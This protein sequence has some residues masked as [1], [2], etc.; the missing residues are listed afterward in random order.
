MPRAGTSAQPPR[1]FNLP[2]TS[3]GGVSA[4]GTAVPWRL[5]PRMS[6]RPGRLSS[7]VIAM[8][9]AAGQCQQ[10]RRSRLSEMEYFFKKYCLFQR[11]HSE[12]SDAGYPGR[13]SA[14]LALSKTCPWTGFCESY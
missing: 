14:E 3:S 2:P 11:Q 12:I 5:D 8:V 4:H 6:A 7:E 9:I 13:K 1:H 10:A